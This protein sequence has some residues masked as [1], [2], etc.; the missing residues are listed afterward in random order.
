MGFFKK[1]WWLVII[2]IFSFAVFSFKLLPAVSFE[3]DLGRDLYE[4]AKISYGNLTLLGPKGS[5]GGLYTAPYYYYLFVPAFLLFGRHLNGILFFNA[6]LFSLSL[7]FFAYLAGKKFGAIKGFLAAGALM[8]FPFFLFGARSPGNGFS[9]VPFFLLFLTILYFYDVSKFGP[10]KILLF[11][12]LLGAVFSSLF[13]YG[14]IAIPV[15]LLVFL[16]SKDKSKF[17]VFLAGVASAFAPLL[18]FEIK[19]NFVMLK[20]TFV[21]KSYLSFVNNTNLPNGVK[22]NKNVFTNALDLAA[23]MFPYTNVNIF[24]MLLFSPVGILS[25]AFLALLLRFQYSFHYFFPFLTLLAFTFITAIL[26][27][28]FAK[29]AL[30]ILIL[31]QILWFPKN[32]YAQAT[33]SYDL[34]EN[35]V[36]QLIS[37][38]WL[39]Q[40]DS[41]NVIQ[42]RGDDA[43]TPAGYEYRYF[44]I[45]SGFE[46]QSEFLYNQSE[47]LIVFSKKKNFDSK[48]LKTWE[49]NEFDYAKVKKTSS[50]SPDA[51]MTVYLLEK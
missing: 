24:L 9:H 36:E 45:K 51:G 32:Y 13:V 33:R 42:V 20:N 40:N 44:L 15:L 10:I 38:Q 4:I 49:M 26:K 25:F 46:P 5:F 2:F 7:T 18:L 8:L 23:K 39:K 19:N 28:K 22:L 37:K 1:F 34:V 31:I 14:V 50:F 3:G 17:L 35:R 43:P 30:V 11:G 48:H 16:T 27:S 12:F 21:D 29:L 41:F 6:F 47:K